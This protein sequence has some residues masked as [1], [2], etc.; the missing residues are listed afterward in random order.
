MPLVYALDWTNADFTLG[1]NPED[2]HFPFPQGSI[3]ASFSVI[4]L[5]SQ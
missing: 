4:D 5:F 1:G 3:S 2:F